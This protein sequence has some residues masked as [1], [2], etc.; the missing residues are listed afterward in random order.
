MN[1]N[2]YLKLS[3]V[4]LGCSDSLLMKEFFESINELL[5]I[6]EEENKDQKLKF[7]E[8]KKKENELF[9]KI[10]ESNMKNYEL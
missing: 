6:R 2:K 9:E 8:K 1:L 10:V 5:I 4:S 7:V 3:S